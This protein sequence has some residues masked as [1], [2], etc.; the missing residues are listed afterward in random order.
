M[1]V[2]SGVVMRSDAVGLEQYEVYLRP[3]FVNVTYHVQGVVKEKS[4]VFVLAFE[5]DVLVAEWE[6]VFNS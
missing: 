5:S 4:K 1:Q 3:Y 6:Y 2:E